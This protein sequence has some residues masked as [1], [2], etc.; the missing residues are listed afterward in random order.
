MMDL[1]ES[2]G[3]KWLASPFEGNG[4]AVIP[5]TCKFLLEIHWR[6]LEL[7]FPFNRSFKEGPVLEIE[8]NTTRNVLKAK[9]GSVYW[10]YLEASTFFPVI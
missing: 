1:K 6:I 8:K 9:E 2:G 7:S 4:I 5:R 3:H 10:A